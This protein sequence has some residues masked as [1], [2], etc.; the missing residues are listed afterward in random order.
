M[1]QYKG[2]DS[3]G[4]PGRPQGEDRAELIGTLNARTH[5]SQTKGIKRL[6]G[7]NIGGLW[8]KGI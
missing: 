7:A 6:T 5:T 8:R 2:R 3:V 1:Y 4:T